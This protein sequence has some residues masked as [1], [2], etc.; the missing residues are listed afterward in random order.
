M[1]Y[2]IKKK[3]K[4]SFPPLYYCGDNWAENITSAKFFDELL[5]VTKIHNYLNMYYYY[6]SY[7][8]IEIYTQKEFVFD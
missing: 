6:N 5:D 3:G 4:G 1:R 8:V 7:V 2:V